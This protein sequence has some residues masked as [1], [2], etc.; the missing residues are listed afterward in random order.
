M[1]HAKVMEMRVE[2]IHH[3]R[4]VVQSEGRTQAQVDKRFGVAQSSMSDLIL[5]TLASRLGCKVELGVELLDADPPL[6]G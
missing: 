1:A 2:L 3:V 5:T 4:L 6:I